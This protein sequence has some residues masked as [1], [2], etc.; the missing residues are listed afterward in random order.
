MKA[1]LALIFFA[2][3][4][5]SMA[6][7]ARIDIINQLVSTGKPIID[8]ILAQVHGQI[9]GLV[10]QA[11]V[12]LTGIIGGRFD[13]NSILNQFKPLLDS[14]LNQVLSGVLGSLAGVLGGR[15][16]INISE[17]FNN[18]VQQ[19]TTPLAGIAQHLANQ[20][21]AAVLGSLG[22]L[23]S[24]G[25]S[26]IFAALQQQIAG[27]VAGAQTAISGVV[28]N[29]TTIGSSIL[30]ASKPHW[31]QLQEQLV[32][33]GLNVLGSL[34]ETINNVHGSITSGR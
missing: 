3:V 5:G 4:A 31:E 33:H 7:D 28:G 25:I 24:R 21:L 13:F 14:A 19:I 20:G 8:G 23:G 6:A 12:Q 1:A 34:S 29:I 30:D 11:L 18:F 26:D 32:G 15:A 16:G 27:V 2:C 17:I 10:Q 9:L 22:G